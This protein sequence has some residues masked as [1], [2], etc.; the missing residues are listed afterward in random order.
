MN[1]LE[2]TE[3]FALLQSLFVLL[4]LLEKRILLGLG[5]G[6]GSLLGLGGLGTA[7]GLGGAL[8]GIFK[9]ELDGRSGTQTN[10]RQDTQDHISSPKVEE[11][12]VT[13]SPSWTNPVRAALPLAATVST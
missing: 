2:Q 4:Q 7:L 9:G 10:G 1:N 11:H 13:M 12:M 5:L 3:E 8:L 6:P